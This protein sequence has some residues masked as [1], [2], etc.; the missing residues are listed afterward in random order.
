[1][2]K[3]LT[4]DQLDELSALAHVNKVLGR[5]SFIMRVRWRDGYATL[6]RRGLVRWGSPPKGFSRRLFAGTRI[7]AKGIRLLRRHDRETS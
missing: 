2:Q 7:T 6:A 5:K 3:P 1:M 4:P